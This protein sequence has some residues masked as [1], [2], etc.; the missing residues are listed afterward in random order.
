M[1]GPYNVKGKNFRIQYTNK[2]VLRVNNLDK[3][4]GF[5]ERTVADIILENVYVEKIC[6]L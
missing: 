2:D 5:D 6:S 1:H 3:I 4:N